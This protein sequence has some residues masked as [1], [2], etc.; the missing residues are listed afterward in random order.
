MSYNNLSKTITAVIFSLTIASAL[1][2][3]AQSNQLPKPV[4]NIRKT[5]IETTYRPVNIATDGSAKVK[6]CQI[7]DVKFTRRYVQY[8]KAD[9]T[10]FNMSQGQTSKVLSETA[11]L[12]RCSR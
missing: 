4:Q 2:V 5:S 7:N 10:T 11:V 1:P 3:L 6:A 8:K 9:G 12:G